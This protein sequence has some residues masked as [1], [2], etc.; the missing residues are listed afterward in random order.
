MVL[1]GL[2]FRVILVVGTVILAID[3]KSQCKIP[4]RYDYLYMP[5]GISEVVEESATY[6][7]KVYYKYD[8]NGCITSKI[9]Y[10]KNG[11][12][13]AKY[14]YESEIRND[15][16]VCIY[17]NNNMTRLDIFHH[18]NYLDSISVCD[19]RINKEKSHCAFKYNNKGDLISM[20]WVTSCGHI[21]CCYE[22]L[23][24]TVICKEYHSNV[25]RE[26]RTYIYTQNNE[27]KQIL[28]ENSDKDAVIA[29]IIPWDE[30]H[31]Y[32]YCIGYSAYDKHGNWTKSYFL[33]KNGKKL[34]SK[35][36]IFYR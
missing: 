11:Q 6:D 2:F 29:D 32:M 7:S 5:V 17:Q 35:R 26:T 18:N 36:K 13:R 1:R 27:L 23:I 20:S 12:I 33:T 21:S 30:Q 24:D 9:H 4:N 8:I 14:E 22:Y 31:Y 16:I 25:L 28:I 10:E 34:R 15:S 3:I 19:G